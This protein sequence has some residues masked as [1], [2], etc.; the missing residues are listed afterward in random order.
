MSPVTL[1][2][3]DIALVCLVADIGN[4]F[5]SEYCTASGQESTRSP[6]KK[7]TQEKK[8]KREILNHL[9]SPAHLDYAVRPRYT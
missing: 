6:R 1:S 3:C 9:S 7:R 5:I 2:I 8:K 4:Q